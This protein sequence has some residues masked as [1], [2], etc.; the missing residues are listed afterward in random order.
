TVRS[1]HPNVSFAARGAEADAIVADHALDDGLG[2]GSPLARIEERGGKI[3]LLGVGYDRNTSFHLAEYRIPNRPRIPG[4]AAI[5]RDD[6]RIWATYDDIDVDAEPFPAIGVAFEATGA[7]TVGK[8]GSADARLMPQPAAVAFAR[9]WML[10][11]WN[12]TPD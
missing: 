6:E 12:E 11:E 1:A 7:V 2:E 5:L 8:V 4:G 10:R 3:L 9:D